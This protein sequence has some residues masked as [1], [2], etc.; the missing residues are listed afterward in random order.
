MKFAF[1]GYPFMQC[2]PNPAFLS[3]EAIAQLGQAA[4]QAGFS[5]AYFTEHPIPSEKWRQSGG[6][7][8]LD[9]FVGLSFCAA[10]TSQLSLLTNLTVLPYRNP[11]LLAKTAASLDVLS[12]GRLIL[13]VGTG[14]LKGEYKALGVDFEERN[15]LFDEAVE[16]LR[17]AWQG[18]PFRLPGPELFR[19]E[20]APRSRLRPVRPP[21]WLGGNSK[22]TRRRVAQWG[23][24]WMPMPNPR[25][26]GRPAPFGAH[27][28]TNDDLKELLA[29]LYE[30]MEQ[31]GR[32]DELDQLDVIYMT[33][34]GGTPMADDFNLQAHLEAIAELRELGVTWLIANGSGD[35]LGQVLDQTAYYG[36]E[37]I[38]QFAE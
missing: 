32:G 12:G 9:P 33:F 4:E 3:A 8:A 18:E 11:L 20:T 35:S 37:I 30:Q 34:E 31:H 17:L 13:G 21:F 27:L 16:V 19:S 10:A 7:D 15:E 29:Y 28:E 25:G 36:Q 6:H 14:Y 5:A 24:G 2:P 23:Q 22:L 1:V 38:S 26:A